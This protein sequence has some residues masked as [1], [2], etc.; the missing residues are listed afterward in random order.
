MPPWIRGDCG[1]YALENIAT[2]NLAVN[3]SFL[4]DIWQQTKDLPDGTRVK[5]V[6]KQ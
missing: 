6:I 5:I 1:D 4:S 2:V 3:Y